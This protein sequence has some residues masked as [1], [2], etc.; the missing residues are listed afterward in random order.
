M[1]P[2]RYDFPSKHAD[3]KMVSTVGVTVGVTVVPFSHDKIFFCIGLHSGSKRLSF[4]KPVYFAL[5]IVL[6]FLSCLFY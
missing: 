1:Y 3:C 2:L 5:F 4:S 6:L